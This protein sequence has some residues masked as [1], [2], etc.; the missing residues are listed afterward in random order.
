MFHFIRYLQKKIKFANEE[1]SNFQYSEL[2]ESTERDRTRPIR[3]YLERKKNISSRTIP[4]RNRTPRSPLDLFWT[5]SIHTVGWSDEV[6]RLL[7]TSV[8]RGE[9]KADTGI[10]LEF[11]EADPAPARGNI[12]LPS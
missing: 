1:F 9:R 11:L 12:S 2:N 3:S 7:L 10:L 6:H 5:N 4:F 8:N